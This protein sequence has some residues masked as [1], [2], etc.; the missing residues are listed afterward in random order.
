VIV[1]PSGCGKTTAWRVVADSYGK[2]GKDANVW[3][4]IHNF[5]GS[6]LAMTSMNLEFWNQVLRRKKTHLI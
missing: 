6:S 4:N 1:G 5:N 3:H 2:S